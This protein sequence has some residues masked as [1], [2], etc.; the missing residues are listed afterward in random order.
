MKRNKNIPRYDSGFNWQ[1]F[2]NNFKGGS[3]SGSNAGA[4]GSGIVNANNQIM[5]NVGGMLNQYST[6]KQIATQDQSTSKNLGYSFLGGLKGSSEG[7]K[8]G[9]LV[10]AIVGGVMGQGASLLGWLNGAKEAEWQRQQ[11]AFNN[12]N[13][14]GQSI[15]Q[16]NA[17]RWYNNNPYQVRAYANG[18]QPEA[19]SPESMYGLQSI[20]LNDSNA[21]QFQSTTPSAQDMWQYG[22]YAKG[23]NPAYVDDGEIIKY[24]NGMMT[25]VPEQGK[26]TDSNLISM[27][28]VNTIFSDKLK[29]DKTHTFA[30]AAQE[31]AN[32]FKVSGKGD[33]F[34]AQS[35]YLNAQNKER[36]LNALA[37]MQAE[38][39]GGKAGTKSVPKFKDGYWERMQK[40]LSAGNQSTA[41]NYPY[42]G[43]PN[44]N[45]N[46]W[47]PD[48]FNTWID[49]AVGRNDDTDAAIQGLAEENDEQYGDYIA[50]LSLDYKDAYDKYILTGDNTDI[51]KVIRKAQDFRNPNINFSPSDGAKLGITGMT[52]G[53]IIGAAMG[54]PVSGVG[55]IPGLVVGGLVGG[56]VN[57]GEYGYNYLKAYT[58]YPFEVGS[59]TP[60]VLDKEKYAYVTDNRTRIQP[61]STSPTSNVLATASV[62]D[63]DE[64]VQSPDQ[65]LPDVTVTAKAPSKPATN[66]STAKAFKST[67]TTRSVP[68]TQAAQVNTPRGLTNEERALMAYRVPVSQEDIVLDNINLDNTTA[69]VT[70]KET[71]NNATGQSFDWSKIGGSLG[72]SAT[73]MSQMGLA[74]LGQPEQYNTI[75]NPYAGAILRSAN[76][77]RANILPA[78]AQNRR[79]NTVGQYNASQS[80]TNTGANMAMRQQ[81][82]QANYNAN[83]AAFTAAD[84]QNAAYNQAY[85]QQM[86]SL[87]QQYVTD[88]Q[89]VREMNAA[90]RAMQTTMALNAANEYS[91]WSQAQTLASNQE[92]RDREV[93][94]YLRQ[95]LLNNYTRSTVNQS[96]YGVD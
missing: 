73:W 13:V 8:Q 29:V 54:A 66:N 38:Q 58:D 17:T 12:A 82:A 42:N 75:Q 15:A 34:S 56:A 51:N 16:T 7:L 94:P 61:Q 48:R 22:A 44:L 23:Y 10:G 49:N 83:L 62:T 36:A 95:Y 65:T 53:A 14:T 70:P 86:N 21:P 91:K 96:G 80:L 78:L 46:P 85:Q 30:Q 39:N 40:M 35:D 84:Q 76:E 1:Q 41:G 77:N 93:M 20:L 68:R 28:G 43:I 45:T 50:R 72:A 64:V 63:D 92:Q 11:Q 88:A 2:A 71:T 67:I 18:T 52:T 37:A 27:N 9:G 60:L 59:F 24:N 89:R 79:L 3:S 6:A 57:T 81:L 69:Q 25:K 19:F 90:S 33:T 74:A 87:G 47:S 26:P 32:K 31:I 5:T 4:I 55:A